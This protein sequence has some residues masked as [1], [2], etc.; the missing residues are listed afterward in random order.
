M[1]PELM[2]PGCA[3]F[4]VVGGGELKGLLVVAE[5]GIE[6]FQQ[7]WLRLARRM[8]ILE[9][10]QGDCAELPRLTACLCWSLPGRSRRLY[11]Y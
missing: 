3:R 11:W 4:V 6:I 10:L 1:L 5:R 7:H 8:G 2:L 9:P